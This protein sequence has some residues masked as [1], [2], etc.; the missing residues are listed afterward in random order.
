MK[1]RN[2]LLSL[3]LAGSLVTPVF[4]GENEGAENKVFL[5]KTL[6]VP[7][8]TSL[9]D[10][11]LTFRFDVKL[12]SHDGTQDDQDTKDV[13]ELKEYRDFGLEATQEITIN[14]TYVPAEDTSYS[15]SVNIL[16]NANF[17]GAG[18]YI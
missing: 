18:E 1:K 9:P 14:Q 2:L 16:A 3:L 15:G 4:A 13:D 5:K 10:S 17:K 8:G 12:L 6:Q 7:A 11:G